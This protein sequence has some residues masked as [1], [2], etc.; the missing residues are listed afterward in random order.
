MFGSVPVKLS[1]FAC[2][3]SVSDMIVALVQ[4]LVC[5]TRYPIREF[6]TFAMDLE[7]K[8]PSRV[9]A[10]LPSSISPDLKVTDPHVCLNDWLLVL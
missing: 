7:W 4:E 6:D 1:Y 3:G 5:L 8:D 9:S 2:H 10:H